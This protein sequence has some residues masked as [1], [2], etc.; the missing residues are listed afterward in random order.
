MIDKKFRDELISKREHVELLYSFQGSKI[1]RGTY[2]H[3]YK[4]TPRFETPENKG[5]TYA[6]KLID[7]NG[8]SMSSCREIA[9]LRELSHPNL[10]KLNRVFLSSERKV[11]LLFDYAEHDLWHIIKFHRNAKQRKQAVMVPKSMVKSLLFQIL[12][13]IHYLHTNWILHRDLKPANILVVGDDP[14][15]R[16]R[17]KVA[18]M[19]FARTFHSP[20]RPMADLDPVVVTFW[21]RAPELLLGAKHYTKAIDI[22]AIGCIFAELLTSEPIFFC[23]EEDIKASS[24]YHKDQ[25]NRIFQVMGYPQEAD[26][27]DLK[28]MPEYQRLL[29]DFK[30]QL[31]SECTLYRYLDKHKI[32]TN[33]KGFNLLQKLLTFDPMKR[34]SAIDA[35][36]D[37]YF[38]ESPKPTQDVFRGGP[39]PYP[40][41]EFM[42]DENEEKILNKQITQQNVPVQQHMSNNIST[43]KIVQQT[44]NQMIHTSESVIKPNQYQN[45]TSQSDYEY[46]RNHSGNI[47]QT[48][49]QQMGVFN[50]RNQQN[51]YMQQQMFANNDPNRNVPQQPTHQES[52]RAP[53]RQ[54][55]NQQQYHVNPQDNNRM[56]VQQNQHQ[57]HQKQ[58][59][60]QMMMQQQN[61]F[62][63]NQEQTNMVQMQH[64]HIQQPYP[65]Q[66][67]QHQMQTQQQIM[68]QQNLMWK[69]Q[70]Q[71]QQQ[72]QHQQQRYQ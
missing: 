39:I 52:T 11:W 12:D 28:K 53:G 67:Q 56:M 44:N 64:P 60:N 14:Y 29:K 33:N 62:V 50:N 8:F 38:Q 66:P 5:K 58:Q 25:L 61:R 35:I 72:Q 48:P 37:P 24:P 19:G 43:N 4:A 70:Q 45:M 15:E 23:R 40:R 6:I 68:H 16:G 71:Q 21:Y 22:W 59:Q 18:D 65:Q 26:W 57:M 54:Y 20:V 42:Q 55:L 49:N 46:R 32:K 63:Q 3:V 69:Q 2:G 17:V 9:L 10:I 1:G 36:N 34:I 51:Q 31:F 7:G 30:K 41:R 27:P 47:N 13:G